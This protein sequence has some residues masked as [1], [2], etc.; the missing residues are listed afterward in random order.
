MVTGGV[1]G[2][3]QRN[4][5]KCDEV[6]P[7]WP[8]GSA[9]HRIRS[10]LA[11]EPSVSAKVRYQ[12]LSGSEQHREPSFTFEL[13]LLLPR[14]SRE[15]A[16]LIPRSSPSCPPPPS[17]CRTHERDGVSF[18]AAVVT[19]M[20]YYLVFQGKNIFTEPLTSSDIFLFGEFQDSVRQ[21]QCP[22]GEPALFLGLGSV[23][24][25]PPSGF[26]FL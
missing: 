6:K 9:C 20:V 1:E 22:V 18:A 12:N 13:L 8:V 3:P 24:G 26:F 25:D 14:R 19:V 23:T 21:P 2:V 11:Q 10:R 15:Q 7:L 16:Y 4:S 17:V 5:S